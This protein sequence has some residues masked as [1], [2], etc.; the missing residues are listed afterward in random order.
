MPALV[1]PL[2][3]QHASQ[4]GIQQYQ[5]PGSFLPLTTQPASFV[6]AAVAGSANL[7][8]S[9]QPQLSA[10][11]MF[12]QQQQ[13]QQQQ[14]QQQP[15]QQEHQQPSPQ[16]QQQAQAPRHEQQYL[17]QQQQQQQQQQPNSPLFSALTSSSR[18]S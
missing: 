13:Q 3:Q 6:G 12:Q 11:Q 16:E 8:Q 9:P 10:L 7:E 5:N 18:A 2:A 4:A 17:Q 1:W 15:L 14:V